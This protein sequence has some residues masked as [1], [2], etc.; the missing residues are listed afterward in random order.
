ML[1]KSLEQLCCQIFIDNFFNSPLLQFR[2]FERKIY[3]CGTVRADRK[4]MPKNLK[5]DKEMKQGDM[6]TMTANGVTCV[7]WMDNRSVRYCCCQILCHVQMT[8]VLRRQAGSSEKLCVPCPSIGTTYN[9]FMGGMD[10]MDQKKVSYETDRKSK[11]KHYL[12]MFFDLL[13]IAV[14]KSLHLQPAERRL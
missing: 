7:K 10:V 1:T 11:T 4:H 8:H 6:D 12:R 5:P 13:D 3:L 9:K 2:L 14:N